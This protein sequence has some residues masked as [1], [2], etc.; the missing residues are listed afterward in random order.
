MRKVGYV[1]NTNKGNMVEV[2]TLAEA[3]KIIATEGGSCRVNLSQI[4][5]NPPQISAKKLEWLKSG[6]KPLHPYKGV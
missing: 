6:K 1:V 4:A 2:K 5:E 3:R